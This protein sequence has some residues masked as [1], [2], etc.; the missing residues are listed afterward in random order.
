MNKKATKKQLAEELNVSTATIHNW[1]KTGIIPAPDN[2]RLYSLHTA[3]KII[4][5][6]LKQETRLHSRAN[7]S[8]QKKT[9]MATHGIKEEIRIRLLSELVEHYLESG[10]SIHEGVLAL[11]IAMLRSN[12]LFDANSVPFEKIKLWISEIGSDLKK[13]AIFESYIIENC[14]DDIIGAFYQSILTVASKSNMGAFYT[15]VEL[16]ESIKIEKDKKFSTH[17]VEVGEF[18]FKLLINLMIRIWCMRGMLTKS[19]YRYVRLILYCF[20]REMIFILMYQK[21]TFL[22]PCQFF[23]FLQA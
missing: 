1:I 23:L 20:L 9:H 6:T 7:R 8:L 10:L 19:H 14:D 13:L 2:G 4:D 15:P 18:C 22:N 11:C 12:N 17:V 16:L 21:S 5:M 3:Q